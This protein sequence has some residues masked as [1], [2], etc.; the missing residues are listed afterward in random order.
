MKV[1]NKSL[2]VIL[3]ES[4]QNLEHF[5]DD[6]SHIQNMINDKQQKIRELENEQ[7]H[8]KQTIEKLKSESEAL[9]LEICYQKVA[10]ENQEKAYQG[11]F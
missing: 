9:R 11:L 8:K 5:N 7:F 1:N 3:E 4:R 2:R 10:L 6:G